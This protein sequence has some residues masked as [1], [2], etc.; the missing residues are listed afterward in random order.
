M[1]DD[2]P[3]CFSFVISNSVQQPVLRVYFTT[4][5]LC[6]IGEDDCP[7]H[8]DATHKVVKEGCPIIPVGFPDMARHF[9]PQGVAIVSK[10]T[11]QDYQWV[12]EQRKFSMK[13]F[14]DAHAG[15]GGDDTGNESGDG[16]AG[17]VD[18]SGDG[19]GGD[20][21]S[22]NGTGGDGSEQAAAVTTKG[23]FTMLVSVTRCRVQYLI[24]AFFYLS[25]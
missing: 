13:R 12:L 10:E 5:R 2:D 11:Y 17:G 24:S 21:G 1:T 4:R 19:A 8:I 23:L 3:F 22:G 16:S 25:R 15:G 6:M 18:G 14:R 20:D 7:V 9:H